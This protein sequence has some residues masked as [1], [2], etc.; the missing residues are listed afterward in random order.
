[1][2]YAIERD[3]LVLFYQP[4]VD[5]KTQG[6]DGVEALVRWKHPYR[7]MIPPNQFILPA[8]RTGLI[9]P[10]TRWVMAAGMRQCAAWHT[11][12]MPL[13]ISVNLSARNL[14]DQKLPGQV[15][16]LLRAT[17][18]SPEWMTFEITESA[19]MAD[20][21]HA[22]K[23]LNTLHDM[24][25]RLS[26]DDFG[27]GYTSLSYLRKLPV[28]RLKVDQSFVS[29]MIHSEGDAMI[30]RSTIDLAHNLHLEVVA[31][32]VESKE[33]YDRLVEWGCDVAQGYYI[34]K[35]L[36]ADELARWFAQQ[37]WRGK[38]AA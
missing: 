12:G 29:Q 35:P 22:L 28:N 13:R 15:A 32:G 38:R 37:L 5:L 27:T 6:A 11:A 24:G 33:I 23:I 7:G 1:M 31:E 18:V 26:I 20:P 14:L 8:E 21:A 30:V 16:E 17:G 9:H 34:S 2:H 10:L 25:I 19:M 4:K 3:E 36:P